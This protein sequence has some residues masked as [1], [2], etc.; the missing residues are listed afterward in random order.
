MVQPDLARRSNAQLK[1]KLKGVHAQLSSDNRAHAALRAA[2][3]T[4][5]SWAIAVE[6]EEPSP[7]DKENKDGR[8]R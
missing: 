8:Y 7:S 5:R 4:W 3:A 1:M 2:E 6:R